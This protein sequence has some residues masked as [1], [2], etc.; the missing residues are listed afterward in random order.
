VIETAIKAFGRVDILVNNAGILRDKSFARMTD[1][2]WDAVMNVHLRGSFK[3]VQAA[4]PH[5]SKQKFGRIVNTSSAVGL[6]GNFGQTNYSTAKAALIAFSNTLALEGK[7]NN[8]LVNTIA[9]NAGTAMTATVMPPEMV[10]ALK[11]EYVAPLIVCLCHEGSTETGSI[12]ECGSGWVS[13]VRWQR[14]GGVGFPVNKPLLPEHIAARWADVCN[15]GDGRATHPSSTQESF[16]AVQANFENVVSDTQSKTGGV[17][18]SKAQKAKFASESYEY[19]EKDVIL[20]AL[21]LGCKRTELPFVYENSEKFVAVPTFGVIPALSYQMKNLSFGDFLPDFNPMMLVHGEQYTEI[22]KPLKTAGKLTQTGRIIDILDKGKG[23]AVILGVTSKDSSGEVV[24]ENQSL[25]FIRG[26]GG[27]GGKKDLDRGPAT[28]DHVPPARPADYVVREKVSEDLAALYRLSGDMNPLHIDP[29]MSAMG[30]FKV[31]ILHGL[32][33]YGIAGKHIFSKYGDFKSIKARFAKH[34]FP[35]ETLEIQM[36]KED[37]KV[38]FTVKVVERDAIAISSAAVELRSAISQ[39]AASTP[40][41]INVP[42]FGAS[43]VFTAME[44]GLNALSDSARTKEVEK[45]K[46][47]FSFT[48]TNSEKKTNTWVVDMKNGKGAVLCSDIKADMTVLVQDKDFIDLATGKLQAQKAFMSGKI[49]IKG[50]MG[51]ANKL[52]KVLKLAAPAS[53]L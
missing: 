4:W 11:P 14:T 10:E 2:D 26:S 3:T 51:L 36:W 23:A 30:G 17:D 29:A 45:T 46:A 33:T 37:Q 19:T 6:Y 31:P 47:V 15:F 9:P 7:R 8:I 34:V 5:F 42:G 1:N 41:G 21:G 49:K 13:K 12:F 24:L 32:C 43:Q 39:K 20:Y 48:I 22:L 40:S 35:G 50:N 52:E 44:K 16:S 25:L 28:T 27:F 53:K 18:V 38:I